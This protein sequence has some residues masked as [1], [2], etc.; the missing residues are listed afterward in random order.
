MTKR[1]II[2]ATDGTDSSLTAVEWAAAEAQQRG[3]PLR[4]VYAYDWDWHD[5]RA[6][7]GTE[8]VDVARQLA[9]AVVAFAYDRAREVAPDA[10]ISTET[11][12]GHAVPRLIE[13]SRGAELLVVGSRGRGGFAGLL[14]GSVSQRMATHAPCP[15]VVVR[16]RANPDGP[17]VAGVD[18]TDAGTPVLAAAFETAAALGRPLTVVHSD[19]SPLPVWLNDVPPAAVITHPEQDAAE[20]EDLGQRLAPWQEKYPD[21][22]AEPVLTHEGAASWLVKASRTA[23]LVIVG[24]GHSATVGGALLGSTVTQLLHHADCPVLITHPH[25]EDQAMR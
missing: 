6:D 17:I 24:G 19:P 14:L 15:V 18:D 5:T 22:P 9:D 7:L 20:R 3:L 4:V 16:G 8:D 13:V 25:V 23:R 11:L 12:V 2:A 1:V 21:V 10:H